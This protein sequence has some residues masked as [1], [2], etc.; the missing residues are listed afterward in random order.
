MFISR[1]RTA[2]VAAAIL[3]TGC[4]EPTSPPPAIGARGVVVLHAVGSLKGL[5]VNDTAAAGARISLPAE[6]DAGGMRLEADTVLTASS[7]WGTNKLY[8]MPLPGGSVREVEMP[9]S[10]NAAGAVLARGFRSAHVAVAL[11]STQ[12]VGLVAFDAAGASTLTQLDDVGRC[13]YDVARHDGSL[14][15]VDYNGAC[16]A[17]YG[18]LGDS[19]LIRVHATGGGRDTVVLT[20][21]KNATG[22]VVA[23]DLAYVSSIGVADYSAW[24]A[25]SF[26]TPGSIT[27]VNLRTR[28]V[29]GSRGLPQGTNGAS[30]RLGSDG[31]L[32][33]VAYVNTSFEQGVFAIAPATMTFTGVRNPGMETLRL[34]SATGSPVACAAA[35]ADALGRLYCAVNQGASMSTSIAVFDLATGAEIRRF[36]TAGTGAV[37]IALR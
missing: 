13:P 18:N 31:S 9:V 2:A 32:Y 21:V 36:A 35:T 22:I 25:V 17:S 34:T 19:R 33:V 29:V 30:L 37:A 1:F 11:R 20:G 3:T 24:P 10:S 6:F 28:Q 14:W 5:T 4:A 23:G 7:S 15:V 27:A 12:A 8:V 26:V 16:D